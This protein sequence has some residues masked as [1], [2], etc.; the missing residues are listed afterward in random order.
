MTGHVGERRRARVYPLRTVTYLAAGLLGA[1]IH[2]A[3]S[4]SDPRPST[5]TIVREAQAPQQFPGPTR[6]KAGMPAGFAHTPEGAVSAA[7][8]FV[9]T[10]QAL[11]DMDPAA[12]E[13][14][15]R[16]MAATTTADAQAQAAMERLAAVR[17]ALA[18]GSGSIVF[19]QASVAA[20]ILAWSPERAQ[21]AIWNVG[22]LSRAGVAPPQA[23][24]AVSTFDLVWERDDWRIWSETIAPGPAPIPD[25]S[26]APTD[27]H[28]FVTALDG[29]VDLG[30]GR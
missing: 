4:A 11:L 25:A 17:S 9:T 26:V 10:G 16:Q 19:R 20:R 5:P 28:T 13:R 7:A 22:V 29:F 1:G 2:A 27:A 12:A 30:S 15:V 23:G 24:W 6:V 18:S 14:A 3:W 8:S 21:V